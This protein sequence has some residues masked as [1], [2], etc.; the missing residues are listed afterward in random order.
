MSRV[1]K[2]NAPLES[3]PLGRASAL[4]IANFGE[5][6]QK[7]IIEAQ[8]KASQILV[9]A[10]AK[11]KEM[12]KLAEQR[13]YAEGLQRGLSDGQADGSEK[14][15]TEAMK[16]F[17]AQTSDLQQ[18]LKQS[19]L[20]LEAARHEILQQAR[21]DL[22]NLSV[23]IAKKITHFQA[24]GDISA[25]QANLAKAIEMVG[26]REQV[27]AKVCPAQ[28]DQLREYAA[29]FLAEMNMSEL[30]KFVGDESLAPGDVVLT[31]RNGEVDARVQT[32]ID[33]IVSALIGPTEESA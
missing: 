21:Q 2:G 13:G 5:Q 31:S 1:I 9:Q 11:A 4:N 24:S 27:Q 25:A 22:L 28:L 18:M 17:Q 33:N 3:R 10:G 16:K 7:M 14:A 19:V 32:Q 12:E 20:Q 30:V 23:A 26:C 29:E 15:F 8:A 6:A